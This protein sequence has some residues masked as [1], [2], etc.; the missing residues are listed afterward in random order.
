MPLKFKF[1]DI[2]GGRLPNPQIL[3]K[4]LED[5]QNQIENGADAKPVTKKD[6]KLNK[7]SLKKAFGDPKKFDSIG[8]VHNSE[9]SYIVVATDK[10]FKIAPLDDI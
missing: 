8:I 1:T 5:L 7:S 3:Y 9:G 10:E 4:Q 6:V 2:F